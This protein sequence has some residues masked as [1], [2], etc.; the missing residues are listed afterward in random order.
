MLGLRR[1]PNPRVLLAKQED[2]ANDDNDD[3]AEQ[4]SRAPRALSRPSIIG[5][6]PVCTVP[7][8]L[9]WILLYGF[10]QDLTVSSRKKRGRPTGRP[11]VSS[12]SRLC[13]VGQYPLSTTRRTTGRTRIKA[14]VC[15][16]NLILFPIIHDLNG[17]SSRSWAFNPSDPTRCDAGGPRCACLPKHQGSVTLF[18][19]AVAVG[20]LG[21][22]VVVP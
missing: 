19:Q 17:L 2:A 5:H 18:Q 8:V 11:R 6:G 3:K 4:H 7:A 20:I 14:L 13:P 21:P 15:L 16:W 10:H 1:H 9:G 12:N 22:L